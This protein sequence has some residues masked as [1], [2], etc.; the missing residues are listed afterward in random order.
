MTWEKLVVLGLAGL[1][2]YKGFK[3]VA[4][5]NARN[6]EAKELTEQ[7]EQR[8]SAA[9]AQRS[10]ARDQAQAAV[11]I[12]DEQRR[13]L[14]ETLV[15][16]A[17]T[18]IGRVRNVEVQALTFG[19]SL[20]RLANTALLQLPDATVQPAHV[21]ASGGAAVVAG[22]AAGMFAYGATSKVA[23]AST[24]TP[25]STLNGAAQ[26][27]AT[28]ARLGGGTKAAGGGGEDEGRLVLGTAVGTVALWAGSEV[29]DAE[30]RENLAKAKA[31]VAEANAAVMEM[32][33]QVSICQVISQMAGMF[34]DHLDALAQRGTVIAADL[35]ELIENAG[36]DYNH[37][38]APQRR[39]YRQAYEFTSLFRQL[40]ALPLMGK[41]DQP[42]PETSPALLAAKQ[43]IASS[44]S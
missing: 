11:A 8:L 15:R 19:E 2:G 37:Y 36:D 1:A 13:A 38:D 42:A 35:E 23:W 22:A 26:K 33:A 4:N 31:G 44:V 7:A 28:F 34:K 6:E 5:G 18:C 10:E 16:R 25:I 3:N 21:A 20:P 41:G 24:G 17:G 27:K 40:L 43:L 12:L 9:V 29:F 39:R 14:D 30:A 32:Q